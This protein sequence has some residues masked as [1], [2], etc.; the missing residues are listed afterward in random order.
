M[1]A[2]LLLNVALSETRHTCVAAD[3]CQRVRFRKSRCQRC[4]EVCPQNAI[5]LD[6]GPILNTRCTDCG[7]CQNACPSE[8]FQHEIYTDAYVLNQVKT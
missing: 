7:L 3:F 5:S 1:D 6:P 4:L 2:G 8:V